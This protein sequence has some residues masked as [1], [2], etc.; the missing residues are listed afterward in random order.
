MDAK[1]VGS[2]GDG[3]QNKSLMNTKAEYIMLL[4][5]RIYLFSNAF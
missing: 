1:A 5:M 3:K 2:Q 4:G